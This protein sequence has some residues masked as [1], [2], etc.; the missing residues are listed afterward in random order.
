MVDDPELWHNGPIAIQL[1]GRQFQD[2]KLL[3]VAAVVDQVVN[4]TAS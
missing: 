3:A 1:V 2:E 4:Q